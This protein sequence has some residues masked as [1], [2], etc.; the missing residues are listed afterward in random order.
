MRT[1]YGAT[2]TADF[3]AASV[4]FDPLLF[5]AGSW[6]DRNVIQLWGDADNLVPSADLLIARRTHCAG[7]PAIDSFDIREGGDR[8][9]THGSYLKV[10]A[11]AL[12][13]MQV[14][15]TAPPQP[16]EPKRVYQVRARYLIDSNLRKHLIVARP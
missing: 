15:G 7:K 5:P 11:T 14:I 13:L 9:A 3:R 4:R 10:D 1:A 12:L 16:V 6:Q 8:S 2:S